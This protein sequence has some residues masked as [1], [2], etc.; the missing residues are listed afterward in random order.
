MAKTKK[1]PVRENR[2]SDQV[3]VD[4]YG[5]QEQ[6]M[7]WSCYLENNIRFPFRAKCIAAKTTSPLR[8]GETVEVRRWLPTM[9]APLTCSS[10]F[11]V[12]AAISP[13]LCLKSPRLTLMK[14][15]PKLSAIGTTG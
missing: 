9:S 14:K 8:K 15:R 11:A 6:A 1:D 10:L 5:S 7:G 3:I 4:A 13:F 2:I 12:E